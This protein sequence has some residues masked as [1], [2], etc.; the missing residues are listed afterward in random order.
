MEKKVNIHVN[1]AIMKEI[2]P[3]NHLNVPHQI[4]KVEKKEEHVKEE[5]VKEE[6]QKKN[7]LEDELK[8]VKYK[9]KH[10]KNFL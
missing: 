4:K 10:F 3:Q 7:K 9:F 1:H 5:R 2:L 6:N 8:D